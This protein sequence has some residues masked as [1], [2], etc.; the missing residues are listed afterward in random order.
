MVSTGIV[1]LF[2]AKAETGYLTKLGYPTYFLMLLGSW[3]ILG[4]IAI[5]IPRS[6]VLKEWAYAGFF[7]TVTGAAF[8]H[9]L[10]GTAQEIFPSLLLLLLT[11]TSWYCRPA[12]RKVASANFNTQRYEPKG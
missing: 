5:L 2:N 9:I 1:Q 7:F 6:P 10:S 12:D 3:K 4:A 8:S 11:V